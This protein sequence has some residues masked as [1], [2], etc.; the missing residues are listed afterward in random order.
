MI[1][2]FELFIFW[3]GPSADIPTPAQGC[4]DEYDVVKEKLE[5]VKHELDRYLEGIRKEFNCYRG[6]N[7]THTKHR[8]EIEIPVTLV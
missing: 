4:I 7:Y 2:E 6:I 3:E 5:R 1:K 8:F